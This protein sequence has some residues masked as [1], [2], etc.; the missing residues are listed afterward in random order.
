VLQLELIAALGRA[1]LS[2]LLTSAFVLAFLS[3]LFTVTLVMVEMV[4]LG[5]AATV[6]FGAHAIKSS[7]ILSVW[8]IC[9]HPDAN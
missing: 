8:A 4:L 6:P 1:L 3:A 5:F 9:C 2:T 7:R